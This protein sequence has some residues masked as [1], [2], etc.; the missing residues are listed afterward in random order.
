MKERGRGENER[1][2]GEGGRERK[3]EREGETEGKK[4]RKEGRVKEGRKR[5]RDEGR[6]GRKG[7]HEREEGSERRKERGRE[8]G[9]E[10]KARWKG[11]KKECKNEREGRK[12]E[13]KRRKERKERPFLK[14]QKGCRFLSLSLQASPP[15]PQSDGTHMLKA[16]APEYTLPAYPSQCLS[17]IPPPFLAPPSPQP[18]RASLLTRPLSKWICGATWF[19][20]SK[21]GSASSN[22]LVR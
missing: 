11:G 4:K 15:P 16:S 8:G 5:G 18:S 6:E 13:R 9:R 12:E 14:A 17:E 2:R 1:K 7:G 3:N 20:R 22:L 21:E 19:E 10:E